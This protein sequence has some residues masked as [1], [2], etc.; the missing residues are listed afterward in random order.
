MAITEMRSQ[1][2]TPSILRRFEDVAGPVSV[3]RISWGAVFAGTAVGLVFQLWLAMF[4]VAIG[5]STIDPLKEAHPMSGIGTGSAVWLVITIIA[6]S[7]VGGWVTGKL[8]G[9]PRRTESA[10]HGATSWAIATMA[11]FLMI[12]TVFGALMAGTAAVASGTL[13]AAGQAANTAGQAGG[14]GMVNQAANTVRQGGQQLMNQGQQAIQSGQAQQQARQVG[15]QATKVAAGTSWG[16]VALMFLGLCAG[17]GGAIA[18]ASSPSNV[19]GR[20]I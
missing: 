9:I 16:I 11:S 17:V 19:Y 12:T 6:A 10:L 13:K 18:G 8:A 2:T 14:P 20:Q 7:F 3:R 5:A 4:G 15:Q 1:T